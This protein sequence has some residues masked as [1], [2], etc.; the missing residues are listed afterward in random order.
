MPRPGATRAIPK[1][2]ASALA[3]G[4]SN[5]PPVF[6]LHIRP[7]FRSLDREHM[8]F[9][10]NLWHYPD[11]PGADPIG[12]FTLILNRLKASAPDVVMPPPHAGGP[13]PQEWIDLFQ[14]WLAAGA[15][16]LS[17]ATL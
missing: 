4:P 9:A 3:A 7:L 15:P 11:G 13:W 8:D 14:R 10:L 17:L 1:S 6:E 16:R 12:H 5:P 2:L